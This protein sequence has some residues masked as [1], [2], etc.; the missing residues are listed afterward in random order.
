MNCTQ[1]CRVH[2]VVHTSTDEETEVQQ[3]VLLKD[4]NQTVTV[5]R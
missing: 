2:S 1:Y 5:L 3:S 4:N